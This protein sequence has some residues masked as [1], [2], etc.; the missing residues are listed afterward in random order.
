MRPSPLAPLLQV[1]STITPQRPQRT[2]RGQATLQLPADLALFAQQQDGGAH[3]LLL[4]VL[5]A[6]PLA[7]GTALHVGHPLRVVQVPLHGLG[8]AG[9]E[10]FC[11]LPAQ[12]T[13][14]LVRIDGVAAVVAGAV[15]D[16]GDLFGVAAAIGTRAQLVQQGVTIVETKGPNE[17]CPGVMV[18]GEIPRSNAFEDTGARDYFFL[19]PEAKTPDPL[20]DDQAIFFRVPEGV[21]VI[22][23]CGHA[24]GVN[25]LDYVC[26]LL[27]E[28]SIYAVIGGIHLL[29]ASPD[30]TK[31]TLQAFQWLQ[32]KKIF[33][34]HCTGAR[35]NAKF[36]ETFPGQCH[37]PS[38]GTRLIF[39]T[40]KGN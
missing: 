13:F 16:V 12:F 37:Y 18:T 35:A 5:L 8:N 14:D 7:V 40:Y 1:D 15:G 21:V 32:V 9:V 34:S 38:V 11:R 30:R 2:Q 24:G 3:G 23:G 25:T 6:D 31:Q 4:R 36:E 10:G 26:H 39:G 28:S 29:L 20:L 19:D 27:G 22:T 17:I 33:L